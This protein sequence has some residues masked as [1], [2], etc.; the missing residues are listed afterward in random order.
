MKDRI[1][2]ISVIIA[3]LIVGLTFVLSGFSKAIDPLGTQ[4]KLHDYLEAV[5]LSAYVP[6]LFLLATSV[7]LSAFEFTLGVLILLAVARRFVSRITVVFMFFM[8]VLTVWIYAADP[9]QDCGCFG[10]AIV[11][12]NA[13]TLLKNIILLALS[14][15]IAVFPTAIDR[16]FSRGNQLLLFQ[17]S[18]IVSVMLSMW[19]LYDLPL[20]DFR[21]YH[22]GADIRKGME[23]PEGAEEPVFDTTFILEK[24]GVRKE[25]T[26][27]E[28][29]DSTWTFI[30]SKTVTVKQG[31]VPPIHDFSIVTADGEDI[32]DNILSNKGYTFL[33]ISPYLENADDGN[34]GVIDQIY[35]FA[36]DNDIPFYCLTASNE[37]SIERWKDLTGAEYPFCQTDGTT[38][39]T[40]IRSN[41]GLVM[42]KGGVVVAKWSHNRLPDSETLLTIINGTNT[43]RK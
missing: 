9:V 15:V 42:L 3:R 27:D 32:T 6:D 2:K 10:D 29:P 1:I 33:L 34:F 13:E 23:I 26:L 14:V 18:V 39:K 16:L 38:L 30:D 41:P 20:I 11:L 25:F 36:D 40:I 24:D 12:N 35:E 21:P 28:Y 37:E 17:G 31:Y 19:C 22:V 5:S 7:A 43:S 4:Y 8:T